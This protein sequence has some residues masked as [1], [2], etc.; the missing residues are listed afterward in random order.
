M[1]TLRRGPRVTLSLRFMLVIF[2]GKKCI[3]AYGT[4]NLFDFSEKSDDRL[5]KLQYDNYRQNLFDNYLHLHYD[6]PVRERIE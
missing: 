1:C 3:A 6:I 2:E 4:N 5:C